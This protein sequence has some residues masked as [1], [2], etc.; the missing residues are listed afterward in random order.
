MKF[1]RPDHKVLGFTLIEL[2]VV[3]AIIGILAAVVLASLNDSRDLAKARKAQ[4][5]MRNIHTAMEVMFNHT[6]LY[7]HKQTQYCPPRSAGGNEV[8][9]ASPTSGLIATDGTYPE[10]QGPYLNGVTDPWGMPYFLDEDYYC[11]AGA[12]GCDGQVSVGV[13]SLFSVLVSCGP[14][15]KT[16]D[17]TDNPQPDNGDACAYNDDNVVYVFC[18]N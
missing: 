15:K 11:T 1:A 7:P 12:V 16:G 3:I 4:A 6:G 10:W 9:L 2:L 18:K 17:D 5:D 14:D 8:N 13:G